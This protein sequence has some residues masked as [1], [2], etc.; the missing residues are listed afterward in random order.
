MVDVI[1]NVSVG[2]IIKRPFHDSVSVSSHVL[3]R[4]V[5]VVNGVGLPKRLVGEAFECSCAIVVDSCIYLKSINKFM[6]SSKL[7]AHEVR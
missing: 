7:V 1:S 6:I 5:A 3:L 2:R 4:S